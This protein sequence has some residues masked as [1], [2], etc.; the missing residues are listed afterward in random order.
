[1]NKKFVVYFIIIQ[2][3]LIGLGINISG[4]IIKNNDNA[5]Y[6]NNE[7]VFLRFFCDKNKNEFRDC[8][9]NFLEVYWYIYES[10]EIDPDYVDKWG[11]FNGIYWVEVNISLNETNQYRALKAH[12]PLRH[13]WFRIYEGENAFY[14]NLEVSNMYEIPLNHPGGRI[15]DCN[16]YDSLMKFPLI[17]QLL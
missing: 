8:G 3:I 4:K 1:M 5:Y 15:K 17:Y 11:Y 10:V 9:E 16:F 12:Y 13:A 2:L 6:S 14:L 7:S